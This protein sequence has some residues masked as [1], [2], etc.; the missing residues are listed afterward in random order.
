MTTPPRALHL[1]HFS[2]Y[3][4]ETW[5]KLYWEQIA[6]A[7]LFDYSKNQNR[8]VV[9][10]SSSNSLPWLPRLTTRIFVS[11]SSNIPWLYS[12][13]KGDLNPQPP[14]PQS[15]FQHAELFTLPELC[16][17]PLAVL[18]KLKQGQC[19][20]K[21]FFSSSLDWRSCAF[22]RSLFGLG[23]NKRAKLLKTWGKIKS[24]LF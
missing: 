1:D 22:V 15:A 5:T 18:L 9:A 23:S 10:S 17:L 20:K 21:K 16:F 13:V 2:W 6:P 8:V 14:P 3:M 19:K 24:L 11:D 4:L 12:V 7:W